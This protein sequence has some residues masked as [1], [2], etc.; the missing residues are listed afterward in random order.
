MGWLRRSWP[1]RVAAVCLIA[2]A[3]AFVPCAQAQDASLALDPPL[4]ALEREGRAHPGETLAALERM[5]PGAPE[6]SAR[7]L[8]LL[9]LRGL[10][11][12]QTPGSPGVDELAAQ[13]DAWGRSRQANEA[14]AAGMLVRAA[15][16]LRGGALPRADALVSEALARLPAQQPA[17]D[18][19][20]YLRVQA[21]VKSSAGQLDETVQV[22]HEAL[23][24]AE[25]LASPWRESDMSTR[26][27]L[28]Y[29]DAHQLERA[30]ELNA[31]ALASATQAEDWYALAAAHHTEAELLQAAGDTASQLREMLAAI[32]C[33]RRAGSK[34]AETV[35]LANM[36]DFYLKSGDYKTSLRYSEQALPLLR[37]LKTA[38][39]EA[40][41]LANMGMA[42]ISMK[43]FDA[44][45]RLVRQ[46]LAMDEQRG[47]LAGM[48]GTYL[49]LGTYLERAGDI[50]GAV[51]A[52]HAYRRLANTILRQNQQRAIVETQERFDAERRARELDLLNR[53]A[54]LKDEQIRRRELQQRLW[55][56]VTAAFVLSF[57]LVAQLYRRVRQ[58]NLA[59]RSHNERLLAQSERDALTGLA[60]RRH[61]QSAM[62]RIAADGKLAGTVFLVDIDHFKHINDQHGHSVGDKVLVEVARRLRETLR[63][64]D[65]VV[66]WG[67]EEFLVVVRSLSAEQ[68]QSLAQRLLGAVAG[69]PVMHEQHA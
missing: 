15:V 6:F 48:S 1:R 13:L 7:R 4:E 19:Y 3:A 52:F 53:D 49:D 56:L 14:S 2:L 24:V 23:A 51:D 69:E 16:L 25:R 57:A 17:R 30:R 40:M 21:A 43:H 42:E 26:L 5:L 61:F 44:G 68:V 67:G 59:L 47:S 58:S 60:N 62:Q 66:R 45:H 34:E 31:R 11:L 28:A 22:Y 38:G 10:L 64:G 20:R 37:E 18:R 29:L 9:T 39:A 36:A 55:W 46:S 32:D 50:Q 8:E 27:A 33:A 35:H 65:L 12:A 63:D 41:T 54:Q